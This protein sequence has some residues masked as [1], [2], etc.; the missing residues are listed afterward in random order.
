MFKLLFALLLLAGTLAAQ[1]LDIVDRTVGFSGQLGSE[2][3]T[4]GEGGGLFEEV[5]TGSV[6]H[7]IWYIR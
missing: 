6:W 5:T 2:G 4:A 1:P 3:Q 7:D